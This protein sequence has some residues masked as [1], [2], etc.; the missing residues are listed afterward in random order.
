MARILISICLCL[1]FGRGIAQVC[2]DGVT[3]ASK[4]Q[5]EFDKRF[6]SY[7]KLVGKK[8]TPK[9]PGG[10]KKLDE[11]IRSR[12]KV[13]AEGKNM[14]FN[15]NF[16]LVIGCD[17]VVKH[18]EQIGDKRFSEMTNIVEILMSTAGWTPARKEGQPVDCVYFGKILV[19]GSQ[20]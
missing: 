5:T 19:N 4:E 1:V 8:G 2:G 10:D 17:G 20:Y 7:P 11:L 15:L 16:R 14:V 3:Y 6:D 13:S 18:A 9:Y 12:L